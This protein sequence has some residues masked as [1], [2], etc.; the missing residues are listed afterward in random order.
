MKIR[1]CGVALALVFCI[2]F[3][4]ADAKPGKLRGMFAMRASP[5]WSYPIVAVV[6]SGALA[7]VRYCISNG[8]CRVK[9]RGQF[10]WINGKSLRTRN[11]L[12]L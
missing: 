12:H 6:P 3:G 7:D 1:Y 9:R 2:G 4:P 11:I 10:A 5:G 8:W